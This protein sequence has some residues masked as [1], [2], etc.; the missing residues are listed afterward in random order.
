M[1]Q[2]ACGNGAWAR[3]ALRHVRTGIMV[4]NF[5]CSL[6][7]PLLF[8]SPSDQREDRTLDCTTAN[9]H[10][11]SSTSSP[12]QM[13]FEKHVEPREQTRYFVND[14]PFSASC[15]S[16]ADHR[17]VTAMRSSE[18]SDRF[19]PAFHSAPSPHLPTRLPQKHVNVDIS[20]VLL[21]HRL[22]MHRPRFIF[23]HADVVVI[24]LT[25][26]VSSF[27]F[28]GYTPEFRLRFALQLFDSNL[29][30]TV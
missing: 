19:S 18:R 29:F 10:I 9:G 1:T 22:G 7:I 2:L 16:E 3:P 27:R 24:P 17:R 25:T 14:T 11:V 15:L 5:L 28:P 26:S 13:F 6:Y 23:A 4:R 8:D 21:P 20:L 12:W 30:L